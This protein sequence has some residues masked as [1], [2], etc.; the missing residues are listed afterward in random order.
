MNNANWQPI[1]DAWLEIDIGAMVRN[2]H[3]IRQ[4]VPEGRRLLAVIKADAYG[5]GAIE[6]AKALLHEGICHFGVATFEEGLEL[7]AL[8][9]ECEILVLG[10]LPI[11]ALPAAIAANLSIT[12][13]NREQVQACQRMAT[14]SNKQAKVHIKLDTGMHRLGVSPERA[15]E[16]I[17]WVKSRP[18]IKLCGVFTHLACA[19]HEE[20]SKEQIRM[21]ESILGQFGPKEL[22]PLRHLTNS[23][24]SLNYSDVYSNLSR[25]GLILY[26]IYP[27]MPPSYQVNLPLEPLLTLRAKIVDLHAVAKGEGVGYSYRYRAPRPALIATI[28]LGYADGIFKA[29]SGKIK[30][31]VGDNLVSQVGNIAMD[32][33]MIDVTDCTQQVAIGDVVTLLDSSCS[34]LSVERWALLA[35]T[36]PYEIL[37]ALRARLPKFYRKG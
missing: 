31:K 30:V 25:I 20:C 9:K 29:L 21:W 1:R 11:A 35:D 26:G 32:Q 37:C 14:L 18:E 22:P 4:L 12:V 16:Y 15:V 5:H 7:R 10:A 28:P 8:D 3:K 6:V 23:V 19:E 24:G 27:E 36:I 34:E 13:F 2:L 33:M 17:R